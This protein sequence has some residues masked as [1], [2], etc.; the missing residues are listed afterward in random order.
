M[1]RAVKRFY[2]LG[3][4]PRLVEARAHASGRAGRELAALLARARYAIAGARSSWVLNQPLDYFLAASFAQA[5]NPVVK[6]FM[7]GR[8]LWADA[9]HPLAHAAKLTTTNWL[10][11]RSRRQLSPPW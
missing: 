7:V 4:K 9:S 3:V 5:T 11:R 6:G 8:T 1:L 2:N 10:H